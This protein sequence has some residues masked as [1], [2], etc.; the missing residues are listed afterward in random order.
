MGEMRPI[1][2]AARKHREALKKS[3]PPRKSS[4]DIVAKFGAWLTG[5]GAG[6]VACIVCAIWAIGGLWDLLKW[7]IGNF[8]E[9]V[10]I[11][12]FSIFGAMIM[13]GLAMIPLYIL[14]FIAYAIAWVVGW[15]C[16]NKWTLLAAILL[17]CVI[18]YMNRDSAAFERNGNGISQTTDHP[19]AKPYR[20]LPSRAVE[21]GY[22]NMSR[23]Q[24]VSE[25][26]NGG[27]RKCIERLSAMKNEL[28]RRTSCPAYSYARPLANEVR[29]ALVKFERAIDNDDY[30]NVAKCEV[31]ASNAVRR[32]VANCR[33][34]PGVSKGR[35]TH[36]HSGQMEGTW[37][38]DSG[39]V[40][41]GNR[42]AQV[43]RCSKC[44]GRGQLSVYEGCSRCNGTG[45]IPNPMAQVANGVNM[46]GGILG[47]VS[48]RGRGM[49]IG[50]PN[51][52]S[53]LPCDACNGRGR[54]RVIRQCPQ[55][56]GQGKVYE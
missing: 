42:V 14:Y 26:Q 8:Q 45:K 1:Y 30:V 32:F 9:S 18:F 25:W 3:L 15:L 40:Q 33:W 56:Y 44:S 19:V 23:S 41:V 6:I 35:G 46:V 10:F 11:G 4:G 48:R 52:R 47:G 51:V 53:T 29:T 13:I 49:R 21:E 55:C 28:D 27:K 37:E 17:A 38:L 36:M 39:Y 34:R 12:I 2:E 22:D 43:R 20:Q 7:L 16:Y 5:E 50:T 54:I 31:D 24:Q